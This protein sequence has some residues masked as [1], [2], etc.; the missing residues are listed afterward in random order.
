MMNCDVF[1]R[2][3]STEDVDP[4]P[5]TMSEIKETFQN[6]ISIID[7]KQMRLE[8]IGYVSSYYDGHF[9]FVLGSTWTPSGAASNSGG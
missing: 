4:S 3:I 8:S 6:I 9:R 2:S 1:H 7:L 5:L